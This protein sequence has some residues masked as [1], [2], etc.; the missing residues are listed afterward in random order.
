MASSAFGTMDVIASHDRAIRAS[1][2]LLNAFQQCEVRRQLA[3]ENAIRALE[4]ARRELARL[5]QI[6]ATQQ[7]Y[8]VGR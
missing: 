3:Q 2:D 8:L 7:T 6:A 5:Q 1:A 4:E